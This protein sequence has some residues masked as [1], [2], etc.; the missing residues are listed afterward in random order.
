MLCQFEHIDMSEKLYELDE[1]KAIAYPIALRSGITALYLFGSYARGE[2]TPN[3]DIDFRVDRGDLA[4]L[5]ELGGLAND[6]EKAF[7]KKVDVLT[8]QM[9]TSAFLDSIRSEEVLIYSNANCTKFNS[10]ILSTKPD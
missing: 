3:S 5:L 9:L 1:I 4:D 10:D 2:A 8:T 6:L 7:G